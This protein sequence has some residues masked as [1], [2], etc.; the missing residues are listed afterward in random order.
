[1]IN[2]LL[3]HGCGMQGCIRAEDE[4][5]VHGYLWAR[6][7]RVCGAGVCV[8]HGCARAFSCS[9]YLLP[10]RPRECILTHR[11]HVCVHAYLHSTRMYAPPQGF[12]Q[13]V[14][15]ELHCYGGRCAC[16]TGCAAQGDELCALPVSAC[17][18]CPLQGARC[19][20]VCCAAPGTAHWQQVRGV[21]GLLLLQYPP[22]LLT[23]GY[24]S[25]SRTN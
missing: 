15:A 9:C 1:M 12:Q 8:C 20:Y 14:P 3:R 18:T 5:G 6:R 10:H 4:C 24:L 19:T 13:Q 11:P 16:A 21:A 17:C 25:S 23:L 7:R 22:P 2:Q